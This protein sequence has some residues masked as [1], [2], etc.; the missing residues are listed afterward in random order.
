[1][2]YSERQKSYVLMELASKQFFISRDA[3]FRELEFGFT[4]TPLADCPLVPN[5]SMQASQDLPLDP[6]C[7]SRD[8]VNNDL[9]ED[10][11]L[12]TNNPAEQVEETASQGEEALPEESQH[13]Q[14]AVLTE[15]LQD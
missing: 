5:L 14:H 4:S 2:R 11:T 9:V 7:I 1:M 15:S 6:I 13:D 8:I 3:V 12:A 10:H